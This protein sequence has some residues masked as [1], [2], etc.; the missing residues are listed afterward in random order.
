MLKKRI[1]LVFLTVL[2]VVTVV[3]LVVGNPF[4]VAPNAPAPPSAAEP[5]LTPDD[6]VSARKT[7]VPPVNLQERLQALQNPP[8][9]TPEQIEDDKQIEK[10]Q[11]GAALWQLNASDATQRIEGAEQ[12]GAYPTR[13]AEAALAQVLTRDSETD[14]RSAAAQSLG[15]VKNPS[16]ATLTAL[17]GAL[18]DQ[19]EDVGLKAL[20]TLQGFLVRSEERSVRYKKILI[21]LKASADSRITPQTT[22]EAIQDI[23]EDQMGS[24]P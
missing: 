18:E 21:G 10:E 4:T 9:L 8:P 6:P 14:V 13:E 3:I 23:L 5:I 15:Y 24:A 7:A 22:R 20:W 1:S 16:D 2:S 17:L 12:L 19:N 11:V